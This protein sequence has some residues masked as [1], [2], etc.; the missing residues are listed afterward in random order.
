MDFQT[1]AAV[2]FVLILALVLYVQRKKLRVQKIFYPFIY[3]LM[4]RTNVGISL[5]DRTAKRFPNFLRYAGYAGVFISFVGMGMIC[6]S[7]IENLLKIMVIPQAASAVAL[8]LPFRVKGTFFVPFFYWIISIFFLVVVHEF[9]HGVV[10]RLYGLKIKSSG[11][12]FLG[13]LLPVVPAAF[14]EPDEKKLAKKPRV[15]QLSVFAAGSFSNIISAFIFLAV[16]LFAVNPLINS[17]I[18]Y[19]GVMISGLIKKDNTTVFPAE[20]AGIKAGEVITKADNV[21]IVTVENL[22]NYLSAKKPGDMV[23]ITTNRTEYS[24]ELAENPENKTLSYMGIYL[25]QHSKVKPSFEQKIGSFVPDAIIWIA[26]LIMWLIILNLGIGL[27]NLV[28]IPIT[29]GGRMM[30]IALLHYLDEEKA[31]KVW[32]GIALFFVILIIVNLMV[33]FFR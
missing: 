28:P 29:D 22:S 9:S 24:F 30:Y 25:L 6:Y 26:G 4:Y 20:K 8:V 14:V 32:K 7:L 19:D 27:F 31:K 10:S 1:Q 3:I 16:L 11:L 15:Q 17:I 12:A 21:N 23:S 5:M 33:G 18:E 2:V 13:I